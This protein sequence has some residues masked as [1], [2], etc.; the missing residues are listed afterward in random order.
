VTS[1][2][3]Q[4]LCDPAFL[5]G[6]H[7]G[8]SLIRVPL[9]VKYPSKLNPLLAKDAYISLTEI[10]IIVRYIA[11]GEKQALGTNPPCAESYGIG[12]FKPTKSIS[13][14]YRK[15]CLN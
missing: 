7:L 10:P 11:T 9:W 6:Y 1:D 2:H 8:N 13:Y 5:H 3:G 14:D 4:G 15:R 12:G